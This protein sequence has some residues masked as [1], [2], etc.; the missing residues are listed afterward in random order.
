MI[1]I[2]EEAEA[3][4]CA[5]ESARRRRH[6]RRQRGSRLNPLVGSG[7]GRGTGQGAWRAESGERKNNKG[8]SERSANRLELRRIS[9][10]QPFPV[11][12][13]VS[14]A[15]TGSMFAGGALGPAAAAV[16][17]LA[18]AFWAYTLKQ[19]Q[20]RPTST[21]LKWSCDEI[22]RSVWQ[23]AVSHQHSHVVGA[24]VDL[25]L[26]RDSLSDAMAAVIAW[27]LS[28]TMISASKIEGEIARAL[29]GEDTGR[30]LREDL[31]AV[32]ARDPAAEGPLNVMLNFKG[33]MALQCYRA[34]HEMY[35]ENG[36][37]SNRPLALW[38]QSRASQFFGVDI[39][40]A[41]RCVHM[42]GFAVEMQ[43]QL[44]V[45]KGESPSL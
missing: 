2:H 34:A 45:G 20:R 12:Q 39:H 16:V 36:P 14:D 21:S 40:P 42:C 8:N 11:K 38:M 23:E 30:R 33:F 1:L 13:N 27:R 41:A 25:I 35:S 18:L 24:Y 43:V 37:F 7:A 26:T 29:S 4:I 28:D 32:L 3:G 10:I 19:T 22:S 15:K 6:E 9:P 31:Q 5:T 17:G 44:P